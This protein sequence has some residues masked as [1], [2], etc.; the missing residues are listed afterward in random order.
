MSRKH[1]VWYPGAIYHIT[2]RG[3]R[4]TALFENRNDYLTY[5]AILA[6]VKSQYLFHLH[7]YCLMT[8]HIHLQIETSK[9]HIKDIMKELHA[10]Y[11]VWFNK[12]H[13]YIGHLFQGRYG[14]KLI[15]E[16]AYFLEVSRYI[17]LN[18]L[19]AHMVKRPQ[20]YRWSSYRA[21]LSSR[22]DPL[23]TTKRTLSYFSNP[24]NDHYQQF[25]LSKDKSTILKELKQRV[26]KSK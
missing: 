22:Q 4:R 17:H 24:K 14:D 18:P 11:A 13:H 1:R 15:K 16:D 3:N 8:N 19:E 23:V 25:V 20:D 21:Y 6:D 26:N 12:E 7:S 2:A 9:F 10:R 5:L